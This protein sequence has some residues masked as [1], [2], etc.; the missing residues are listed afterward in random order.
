MDLYAQKD[1]R[2]LRVRPGMTGLWQ[3]SGRSDIEWDE[4]IKLDTYYVE[5]W[6]M[7]GDLIIL[8]RTVRAVLGSRG[9]Y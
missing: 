8:S 7:I 9:A 5:N 6:S 2:R 4:A 1:F 3:V